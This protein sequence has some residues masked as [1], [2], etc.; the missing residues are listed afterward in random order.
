[1]QPKKF[2]D[3]ERK[4]INDCVFPP[5]EEWIRGFIDAEFVVTD[6]FHGTVFSILFNK[7]FVSIGN[8]GR[9]LSRF[10]SLLKMFKLENRLIFNSE[11]CNLDNLNSIDWERTNSILRD[12]REK[13]LRFLYEYFLRKQIKQ[14]K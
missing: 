13:S 7:P 5:V 2:Y 3:K 10:T 11:Y 9:G 1:M 14:I 8:K 12:K 4:G 6:S